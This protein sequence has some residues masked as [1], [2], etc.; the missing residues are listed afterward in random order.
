MSLQSNFKWRIDGAS[1][2][3]TFSTARCKVNAVLKDVFTKYKMYTPYFR[4]GRRAVRNLGKLS[5]LVR[6]NSRCHTGRA[7]AIR[8]TICRSL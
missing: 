6:S 8:I 3:T 7:A 5:D 4:S 1:I 2:L